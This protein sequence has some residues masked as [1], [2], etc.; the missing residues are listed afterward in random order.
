MGNGTKSRETII[1]SSQVSYTRE[2][3]VTQDLLILLFFIE[4]DLGK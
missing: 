1:E 2:T 3:Y 4:S